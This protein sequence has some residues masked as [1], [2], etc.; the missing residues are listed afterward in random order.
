[1]RRIAFLVI[2]LIVLC[3][4]VLVSAQD[5]PYLLWNPINS[6]SGDSLNRILQAENYTGTYTSDI[7][8]ILGNMTDYKPIFVMSEFGPRTIDSVMLAQV[9]DA[10]LTYLNYGGALYWE[11][12]NEMYFN[13]FYRINIFGGYDIATCVNEPF[14]AIH[15]CQ[16]GPFETLTEISSEPTIAAGIGVAGDCAFWAA[17]LCMTKALTQQSPHKTLLTSF[18][19]ARLND[20]GV[21]SRADYV[22]AVMYWLANTGIDEQPLNLP[23]GIA[24]NQNYPNPFNSTTQITINSP[25]S[26]SIELNI[27][28]LIGQKVE[29]LFKGR[30]EA[31]IYDYKWDASS[32]PS[33]VYFA[34]L[35]TASDAQTIR[36]V[37]L[38]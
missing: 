9:G 31:G 21:N 29:T 23:S 15:G 36:M 33:G 38:K 35:E 20:E 30:V 26:E 2:V 12:I 37:Y 6:P 10:F 7:S 5:R 14:T 19:F 32:Y 27:Y 34:R 1:M 4:V 24:L 8:L 17:D 28:N 22:N 3:L 16:G 13:D 11:G 25:R 18:S